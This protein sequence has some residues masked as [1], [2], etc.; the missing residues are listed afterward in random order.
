[1]G[2]LKIFTFQFLFVLFTLNSY[3]KAEICAGCPVDQDLNDPELKQQLKLVLSSKNED[4]QIMKLLSAKTQVVDGIKYDVSFQVQN[5]RTKEVKTC[6]TVYVSRPWLSKQL[7]IDEFSCEPVEYPKNSRQLLGTM[8]DVG[9][10]E[11]DLVS[12]LADM[13]V[14]A[15]DDIDVD[16][17]K[18]VVTEI[19]DAKKQLVN[20][21]MYHLTLKVG[22]TSCNEDDLN[23]IPANCHLDKTIP[24]EICKIKIHR[25][26]ADS[27]PLNARFVNSECDKIQDILGFSVESDIVK[28]AANFA[29]ERISDMSNSIYKQV[30]LRIIEVTSQATAGVKIDL[31]L[32]L[33][34]TECMKNRRDQTNCATVPD[35]AEKMVC[36]V[37]VLSEPWKKING[38]SYMKIATFKCG[39]FFRVKRSIV[40]GQSGLE[41]NDK[42]VMDLKDYIEDELTS[43]S[44]SQHTK[45]IVKVLN[46]TTQVV[47]G[48]MTR[49]SV[50]VADTNCLKDENKE[51]SQCSA[52]EQG[53]Q[54]CDLA[55]WEQPWL[56]RK[57]ITQSEC[58]SIN[59]NHG[60][61]GRQKRMANILEIEKDLKT[62]Q[63]FF[64]FMAREGKVY[65]NDAE[66]VRRFKIFR[67]NMMKAA[68]YQKHEQ[69]T[70]IYGATMFADLTAEEFK[71]YLGF[72]VDPNHKSKVERKMAVV[73][74]ITLPT[75][76]D[77]RDYNAVTSVKNQGMCG[78]C[79]AFSVTGNIEGLWAIKNKQLLSLSEQELVDC[80]KYDKGCMGGNFDT[81][82]HAI[83]D[84][85]GLETETDYPYKG[86]G[87]KCHFNRSEAR[88][89]I[90]GA[91]NVS[92]NEE[93][94]AKILVQNGPISVA[95]NANA[96]QFYMGG[97]S[98]PLRFL[99][100]P[101]N[102]DHGV[103]LVGFGVHRTRFTHKNLPYWLI[104]NSWGT[105]WGNQGYYMLYRGDGSCGVNLNPTTAEL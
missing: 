47:S 51:K 14:K 69:G 53:H 88:V 41:I 58:H 40:G 93:D 94:M 60:S 22:T 62:V 27:S 67:A 46:A 64:A 8:K 105:H 29:A 50:E 68:F 31:T 18:K 91:Y 59:N 84:I 102:L 103:L 34:N 7:F 72:K 32:E 87:E 48:T 23:T 4:A 49:I 37:S 63:D 100:S 3:V 2:S 1:M 25:S 83:E 92:H 33:G 65:K 56:Q 96:M 26:F 90:T 52:T 77:W 104:K 42:K 16:N 11:K 12:Q 6:H 9:A 99:C 20:G 66:M 19:V 15:I 28:E 30:L 101:S 85:G 81:A 89:S 43:R 57:E 80:D 76:F 5:S 82:Y 21:I 24:Q 73:P 39:P 54:I 45:T 36:T 10:D 97:V 78:S 98:H 95:V 71:K 35:N 55:I 44:N 70:A 38:K 75:E 61:N 17:H 86:W 74:N 79:W 13:A